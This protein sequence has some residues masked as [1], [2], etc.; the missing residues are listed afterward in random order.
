[1]AHATLKRRAATLLGS[2]FLTS[3]VVSLLVTLLVLGLRATGSLEGWSLTTYDWLLRL[4]PEEKEPDPLVV[5]LTLSE[6]DVEALGSWPLSDSLMEQILNRLLQQRPR[7]I[8][9][10][11]YRNF[12]VPP[13]HEA[14]N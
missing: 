5:L 12:P 2:P 13:G 3:V 7:V 14:L 9:V 11:I 4:Q 8:G 10:D 6:K 1:M